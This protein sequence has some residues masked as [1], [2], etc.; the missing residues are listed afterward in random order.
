MTLEDKATIG[1]MAPEYGATCGFFP[2]DAEAIKYLDKSGRD[3]ARASPWSRPMPRR[4]ACS[5]RRRRPTRCSPT[6]L[7]LDLD[8]RRALARRAEAP[9]G[10]GAALACQGRLPGGARRRVQEAGRDRARACP[11]QGFDFAHPAMARST[12][13][14]ITS[15]TNTSNP[16]VLIAA[17]LLARKARAKGL[18][19]EALGQDLARAGL[20]GRAGLSRLVRPAG[21]SRRARLQPRRLRLHHLHRQFRPAA[22]G[23]SRTPSTRATSS[24][25]R[26][27]PAIATSRAASIRT[28]RRT[29]SPRRRSSSPMRWPARMQI[30]LATEP[31][32]MGKDGNP[33]F[34]QGHLAEPA[35]DPGSRSTTT[36][37]SRCSSRN[38][39][40]CSRATRTGGRSRC[41]R[42]RPMPGTKG[43]TYV[44]NPPYF[45]GMQQGA[46]GRRPT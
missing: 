14:A 25:P 40:T 44:Q 43:S 17:G 36:S 38:M 21:R 35:R 6:S 5:A 8:H 18:A 10:P 3:P 37:P 22:G 2:V 29:T 16:S 12:I 28:S 4:R 20:A 31:L 15:C 45:V 1:N 19:V 13:A 39:P 33:V 26:C 24:P 23:R 42:A 9:A 34:L 11:S 46:R 32:G 7:E 30:D 41:R 27:C